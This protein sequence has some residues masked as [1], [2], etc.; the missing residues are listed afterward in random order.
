M[1]QWSVVHG[2]P[3][4]AGRYKYMADVAKELQAL[5]I[6]WAW[7]VWRG[8][9]DGWSHGS[10]ELVYQYSNGTI[11][12]DDQGFAALAPYTGA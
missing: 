12:Y 3:A 6:G 1:N 7:W 8:G 2:V 4:S 9:G 10:S 11:E 5:G